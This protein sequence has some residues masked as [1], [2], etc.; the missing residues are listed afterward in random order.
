MTS[1][2]F[3]SSSSAHFGPSGIPPKPS[4]GSDLTWRS[5]NQLAS[6]AGTTLFESRQFAPPAEH[7]RTSENVGKQDVCFWLSCSR[8]KEKL[9]FLDSPQLKAPSLL[10][11]TGHRR[12]KLSKEK[13][14]DLCHRL[15]STP[16]RPSVFH[17]YFVPSHLSAPHSCCL[18]SHLFTF[19]LFFFFCCFE[20]S[21]ILYLFYSYMSLL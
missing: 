4:I 12:V 6:A 5:C 2:L 21:V 8:F 19:S 20:K 9:F 13:Q 17:W 3:V 15:P 10:C 18:Q 11:S 7:A 16:S 1:L 14:P